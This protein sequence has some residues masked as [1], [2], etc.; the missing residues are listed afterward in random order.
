MISQRGHVLQ[1]F[2]LTKPAKRQLTCYNARHLSTDSKLTVATSKE[3][4]RHCLCHTHNNWTLRKV[5]Y[6]QVLNVLYTNCT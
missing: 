5:H 3:P 1:G 2:I 4:Y 6:H